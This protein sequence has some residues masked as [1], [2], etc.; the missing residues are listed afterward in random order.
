M[1]CPPLC[2]NLLPNLVIQLWA[3]GSIAQMRL[4]VALI[5]GQCQC[6][7]PGGGATTA[8]FAIAIN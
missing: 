2:L 6:I 5:L 4:S 3:T 1:D 8:L 7:R